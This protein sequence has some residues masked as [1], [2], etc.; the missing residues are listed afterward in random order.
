MT[1][2]DL[3][4]QAQSALTRAKA[5]GSRARIEVHEGALSHGDVDA[6]AAGDRP[7]ARARQRGAAAL[8]PAD[9]APGRRDAARLRGA[10]PLAA[11]D[12]RPAAAGRL[13]RRRREQPAHL[14]ARRLGARAAP[15]PTPPTW[16]DDLRV[17]VNISARHLAEDGLQRPGRRRARGVRACRRSGSS[18][19]SPSRRRCSPPRPRCTRSPSSPTTGVTLALDDFGTGYSAI[20]ALHRLP[21]HTRQD[22]PLVRRRRRDRA[23]D[24]RAGAGPA[25]ARPRHGPAGHRRGHRGPRPGGLA[26]RARLRDGAGLRV[27]PARAAAEPGRGVHRR[28]D[29]RARRGRRRRAAPTSLRRARPCP[30]RARS[31]S[32]ARTG[33]GRHDDT[34]AFATGTLFD[35]LADPEDD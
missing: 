20:T 5:D 8:L 16:P 27:R 33:P 18:W 25:A 17:H 19:R 3:L 12:P 21:I 11:P 28:D 31:G 26:A 34:G 35:E 29:R 7:A 10:G 23:G 1:P 2:D 6:A 30:S 14:Q 9:R 4:R 32:T 22:R 24:G 13:P 15:A